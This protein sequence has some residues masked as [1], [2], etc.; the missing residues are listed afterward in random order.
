M[1]QFESGAN[2]FVTSPHLDKL[3]GPNPSTERGN[4]T[5]IGAHPK[6]PRIIYP[7]G[8]FVVV[9]NVEDPSDCFI[10]RGHSFPVTVAK[11]STNGFWVASADTS[12]KIRVW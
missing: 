3:L 10:Y 4:K 2:V 7:C 12:G 8:K 11:F 5:V 9:K 1:S 6:E